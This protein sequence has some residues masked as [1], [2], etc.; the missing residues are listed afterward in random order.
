MAS[1]VWLISF[2]KEYPRDILKMSSGC[3]DFVPSGI[4]HEMR[5][6]KELFRVV[7]ARVHRQIYINLITA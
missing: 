5:D 1:R 6:K 3:A 7:N 4:L 2:Y